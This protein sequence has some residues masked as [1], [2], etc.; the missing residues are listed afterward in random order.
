MP[1]DDWEKYRRRDRGRRALATGEYFRAEKASRENSRKKF[2][3]R[4]GDWKFR[5]EGRIRYVLRMGKGPM[6][7]WDW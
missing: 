2:P 1:K 6:P 5:Y 3:K 7:A 4:S